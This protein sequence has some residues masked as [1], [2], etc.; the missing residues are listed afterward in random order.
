MLVTVGAVGVEGFML[1]LVVDDVVIVIAIALNPSQGQVFMEGMD[2]RPPVS[3]DVVTSLKSENTLRGRA[4][5]SGAWVSLSLMRTPESYLIV[6]S[7]FACCH[8]SCSLR[9]LRLSKKETNLVS[10]QFCRTAVYVHGIWKDPNHF[11]LRSD[12]TVQPKEGDS[13][14]DQ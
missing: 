7:S 13:K 5:S 10:T 9:R 11:V 4:R 14:G 6:V 2:E 12:P 1:I 3:N 8:T